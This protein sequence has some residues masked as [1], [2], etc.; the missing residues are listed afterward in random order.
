MWIGFRHTTAACLPA[1]KRVHIHLRHSVVMTAKVR[2]W[3]VEKMSIAVF[4]ELLETHFRLHYCSMSF[5]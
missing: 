5:G 1:Q 3:V 4:G 2:H